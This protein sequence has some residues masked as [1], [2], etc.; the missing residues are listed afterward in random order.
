VISRLAG[1]AQSVAQLIRNQQVVG[2]IPTAGSRKIKGLWVVPI[3]LFDYMG[4]FFPHISM[5]KILRYNKF[6]LSTA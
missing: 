1:V 6:V 3:A 2:S 5:V 4:K